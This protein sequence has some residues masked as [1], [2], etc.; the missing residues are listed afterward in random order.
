V[1]KP[2]I[3]PERWQPP[4]AP[5]MSGVYAPNTALDAPEL[6]RV[7]GTGPEDVAVDGDGNVYTG[8]GDG[9][10]L[11]FEGGEGL[12]RQLTNTGGRP[13]GIEVHPDGDLL[14]CDADRGLLRVPADGGEP[15][16]LLDQVGGRRL[17]LTNNADVAP[18]GTIYFTESSQRF[19][20]EHFRA[21]VLEHSATGRLLRVAPDGEVDVLLD[22]LAF[23]NGVALAADGASVL[24]A[25][26]AG[27]AIHRV[28]LEGGF[29]GRSEPFAT[30]LPGFPDN[31]STGPT[32]T[33]WCAMPS[34]RNPLVDALLPRGPLL[35]RA[36]WALPESVQ[37]DAIRLG[38][39]LGFDDTGRV[40]HN[41]QGDGQAFHYVTGVR[42]H[43]G[44]LWLGSLV[45][46]A[47]AKVP[48]DPS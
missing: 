34:P 23:A 42:E 41:L 37:P 36:I 22:G 29:A 9:R 14:V 15:R 39:V 30:N 8:L 45:E 31:L 2:T 48:L 7:P 3:E 13:L 35:R 33:V 24:V 4:K 11:R 43:A 38:F 26:T 28:R 20:L 16:V 1:A 32:G 10:I 19:P 17:V 5:E 6:L 18:D 47:I 12:P 44:H 27:Y 46:H 21:D 40:T 25:E